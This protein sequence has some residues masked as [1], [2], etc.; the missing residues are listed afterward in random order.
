MHGSGQVSRSQGEVGTVGAIYPTSLD[1]CWLSSRRAALNNVSRRSA[2][3]RKTRLK[4]SL[5]AMV[6]TLSDHQSMHRP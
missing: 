3:A 6:A 5:R 4:K 2:I 1:V